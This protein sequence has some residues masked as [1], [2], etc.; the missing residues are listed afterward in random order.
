MS[1]SSTG[2]N[3]GFIGVGNMGGPMANNLLAAGHQVAVFDRSADA[4]A[5]VVASGGKPC[6]SA[7]EA[8]AG[9]D[10][11]I[12]MLPVGAD[13]REV[14]LDQ[15]RGHLA[16]GTLVIDCSTIDV[17]SARA[18]HDAM[19]ALGLDCLDAPV[20]G[21][22][23]GATAG[24][25]AFMV[26][27]PKQAFE[28]ARP[29]LECMG[30][31]IVHAGGPG[32]GQAAKICNNTMLGIQML[33]VCEGF[34]LADRLGLD[35]Q[36]LFDVASK[37]SGQSWALT[38]YCPVPGPV[39]TSPANN[40]YK[41]GFTTAMML[42][43]MRLGQ[44]EAQAAGLNTAMAALATQLYAQFHDGGAAASDFSGVFEMIANR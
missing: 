4:V 20:S 6:T 19:A 34:S 17:A 12:S 3:I 5:R 31:N 24:T 36:T 28:R 26:G 18:L 43:D 38:N 7:V 35:R 9:R 23:V 10:V 1:N 30:A 2:S 33:A 15:L 13:V 40:D 29:L 39:P 8:A 44:A 11:I 27:G 25:L 37:S 14:Y 42:K 16:S 41:P 22:V 32:H 21:G